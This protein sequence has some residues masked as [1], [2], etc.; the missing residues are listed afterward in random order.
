[1][2]GCL[3][4]ERLRQ[5]SLMWPGLRGLAVEPG[6]FQLGKLE[7]VFVKWAVWA[8]PLT[9]TVYLTPPSHHTAF[10]LPLAPMVSLRTTSKGGQ[11]RQ[12]WFVSNINVP[13]LF[14]RGGLVFMET[15]SILH[16]Q[17]QKQNH[18]WLCTWHDPV[19]L[20]RWREREIGMGVPAAGE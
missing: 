17:L 19:P 8:H 20:G 16:V 4:P 13:V 1:M 5:W 6:G 10:T 12:L 15:P 11:G 9:H 7:T 2:S 3:Q 14:C 18:I